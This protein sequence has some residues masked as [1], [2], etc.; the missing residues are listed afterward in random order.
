M[1]LLLLIL[2]VICLVFGVVTLIEGGVLFGL[3]LI[4]VGVIL[5]GYGREGLR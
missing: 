1:P 3:L 2:A 5:G 4:V